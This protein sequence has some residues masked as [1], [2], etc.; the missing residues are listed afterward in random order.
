MKPQFHP[1]QTASEAVQAGSLKFADLF[2]EYGTIPASHLW[3]RAVDSS[4]IL[5]SVRLLIHCGFRQ[6]RTSDQK[7]I[8]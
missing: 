4:A 8:S 3:S 7:I 2:H 6:K 1:W 5:P